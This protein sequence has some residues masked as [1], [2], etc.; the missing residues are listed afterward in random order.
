MRIVV[1]KI[2]TCGAERA[3]DGQT[4]CIER[5]ASNYDFDISIVSIAMVGHDIK[6]ASKPLC[7]GDLWPKIKREREERRWWTTQ[8][9]ARVAARTQKEETSKPCHFRTTRLTTNAREPAQEC[10][11]SLYSHWQ[12]DHTA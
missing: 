10:P 5:T 12:S 2:R 7:R 9:N 6:A 8:E 4:A 11:G 1:K 3:W